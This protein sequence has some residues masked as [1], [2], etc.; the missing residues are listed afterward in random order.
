MFYSVQ[1]LTM[2]RGGFHLYLATSKDIIPIIVLRLD[3]MFMSG[4]L[5]QILL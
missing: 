1:I 2:K 3:S 5:L 4:T